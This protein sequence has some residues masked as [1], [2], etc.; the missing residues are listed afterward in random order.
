MSS[1]ALAQ[2]K[3]KTPS[4]LRTVV[5]AKSSKRKS[6]NR[7]A[8]R[9]PL[10]VQPPKPSVRKAEEKSTSKPNR[11]IFSKLDNPDGFLELR[12][13]VKGPDKNVVIQISKILDT[14]GKT[15]TFKVVLG[16]LH[17]KYGLVTTGE[18]VESVRKNNIK[19]LKEMDILNHHQYTYGGQKTRSQRKGKTPYNAKP[20]RKHKPKP[21]PKSS[22]FSSS[23]L[24]KK[25][26][27]I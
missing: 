6:S 12:Q 7:S 13:S 15:Q 11:L 5:T 14:S 24:K 23:P 26:K 20:T 2:H 4:K 21:K 18:D 9:S 8:S 10:L 1:R 22:S 3:P 17:D 19:M 16:K 25:L 27:S